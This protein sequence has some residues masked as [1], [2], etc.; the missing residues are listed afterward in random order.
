MSDKIGLP[1]LT[2]I[3]NELAKPG[4]D[5]R[6]KI[7]FFEFDENIKTINDLR[8]GLVLF[9]LITNITRFGAFVDVGIKENG[10][11]HVSQLSEGF[12]NDPN[13]V[14]KINQ[15]VKVKVL[16]IDLLRKRIQLTM[17]GLD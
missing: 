2:D 16:E 15:Q 13:K 11:V 5:P 1:T 8:P 12:V 4:R 7:Q 14:V 3:V 10:L 9:G 17:K 6:E